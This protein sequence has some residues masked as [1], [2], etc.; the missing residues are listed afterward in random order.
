M[1]LTVV[2]GDDNVLK[3]VRVGALLPCCRV[4]LE[5]FIDLKH[6]PC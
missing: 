5:E 1:A 3:R 6:Q 2:V 4:V